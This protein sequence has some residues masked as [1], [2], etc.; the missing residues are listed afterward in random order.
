MPDTDTEQTLFED[1]TEEQEPPPLISEVKEALKRINCGNSP[2]QDNI[3]A[4]LFKY[5]GELGVRPYTDFVVRYGKET[6][7]QKVGDGKSLL[8]CSKLKARKNVSTIA[9]L[10]RSQGGTGTTE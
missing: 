5:S 1:I 8:C 9:Q 4:E 2:G 7:G 6:N 3:L 10:Y